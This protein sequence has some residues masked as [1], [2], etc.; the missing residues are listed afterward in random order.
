MYDIEDVELLQ[1][2]CRILDEY[3][4]TGTAEQLENLIE[5]LS[6]GIDS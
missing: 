4:Y 2:V 1:D 5:R 6:D 3:G